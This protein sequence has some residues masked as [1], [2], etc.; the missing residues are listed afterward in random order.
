MYSYS[1]QAIVAESDSELVWYD[2]ED[3]KKCDPGPEVWDVVV[4][5]M[6]RY[7]NPPSGL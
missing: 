1:Q 4:R 6:R 7:N 2:Y 5:H 3:L